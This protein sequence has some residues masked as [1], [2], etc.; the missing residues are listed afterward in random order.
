MQPIKKERV[1]KSKKNRVARRTS[2]RRKK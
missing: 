2:R 1:C